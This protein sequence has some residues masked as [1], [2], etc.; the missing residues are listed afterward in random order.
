MI[1]K[2]PC[3]KGNAFYN[4]QTYKFWAKFL[5]MMSNITSLQGYSS[6]SLINEV[7]TKKFKSITSQINNKK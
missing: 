3:I 6:E 7:F 2:M 5:L 4:V 1:F